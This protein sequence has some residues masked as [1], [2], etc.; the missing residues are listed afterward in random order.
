MS[1]SLLQY[2][3]NNLFTDLMTYAVNNHRSRIL[4]NRQKDVK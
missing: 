4:I 1:H 3:A 2:E